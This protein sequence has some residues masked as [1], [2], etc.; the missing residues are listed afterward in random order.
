MKSGKASIGVLTWCAVVGLSTPSAVS[1]REVAGAE[2][3]WQFELT[4][5]LFGAGLDGTTGVG[6]V[7]ADI[8]MSFGDMLENIDSGFMAMFE[9]RKGPWS[10]AADGVYFRLK[11]QKTGSWQGP[12]GIGS[13]TGVLEAS[14]TDQ[15]YQ[16]AVGYRLLDAGT[17]LDLVGAARYTQ[18]DTDLNLVVTTGPVL[19]GGTRVLSASES[20]WDPVIGIRVIAPFAEHWSFVG[21][22]DMGGFGV[23][24]DVT[25]QAIA[26]V[27]W[28]FAKSF[29]A[30]AGYRYF[31]QDYKD[32]GFV[33]DMAAHGLYLG[34]GIR[35]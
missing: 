9:A 32:G 19:P 17:K 1:A 11:D 28:Q 22:A 14:M 12:G 8:G 23:G 4:P 3:S 27:N 24:S 26:G 18:L 7:T 34:L 10:L 35:F 20:W 21:Y 16:L 29:V 33:W 25:Y 15:V 5:Y 31:Y 2:I 30:K 13:A 6:G